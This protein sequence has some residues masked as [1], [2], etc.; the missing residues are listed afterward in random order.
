MQRFPT[1]AQNF[2]YDANVKAPPDAISFKCQGTG[3]GFLS[4]STMDILNH[5]VLRCKEQ[6][7]P[8]PLFTRCQ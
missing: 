2:P 8:W 1:K 3:T 5:T 6:Q 4:L 7:H